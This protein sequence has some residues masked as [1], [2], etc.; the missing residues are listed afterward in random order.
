VK[1][2]SLTYYDELELMVISLKLK[3]NVGLIFCLCG[4]RQQVSVA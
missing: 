4:I 2:V 3:Y 1:T